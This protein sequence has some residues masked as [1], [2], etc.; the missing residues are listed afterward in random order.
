V[1]IGLIISNFYSDRARAN[2]YIA[3]G[4]VGVFFSLYIQAHLKGQLL[5]SQILI[6]A[7]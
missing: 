5:A 1:A 3:S 7:F 6:F 4:T 2:F